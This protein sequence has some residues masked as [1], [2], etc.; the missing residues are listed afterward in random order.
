M[1]EGEAFT[2]LYKTVAGWAVGV[3]G[4]LGTVV[5]V[6]FKV[7]QDKLETRQEATEK[8]LGKAITEEKFE[9]RLTQ[10][11]VQRAAFHQEN[12]ARFD[13]L[14]VSIAALHALAVDMAGFKERLKAVEERLKYLNDWKHEKID[15]YV[16]KEVTNHDKRIE[17]LEGLVRHLERRHPTS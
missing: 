9:A 7:K 8:A 13:S 14:A 1:T 15:P 10:A 12:V 6:I 5:A 2:A 16:P 17:S 4:F 3:I 11:D